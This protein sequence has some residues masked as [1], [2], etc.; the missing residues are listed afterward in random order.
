MI[1]R[2]GLVQTVIVQMRCCVQQ[3]LIWIDTVFVCPNLG[4][5]INNYMITFRESLF[6]K[7][8]IC[9]TNLQVLRPPVLQSRDSPF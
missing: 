6:S 1:E 7:Q 4:N 3:H 5:F 8:V 9:G 2:C